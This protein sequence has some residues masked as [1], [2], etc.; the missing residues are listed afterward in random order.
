MEKT[1]HT[2]SIDEIGAFVINSNRIEGILS[3]PEDKI[4]HQSY[5]AACHWTVKASKNCNLLSCQ[6]VHSTI[7]QHQLTEEEIGVWR[8]VYVYVGYQAMPAPQHVATL[9]CQWE[10]WVKKAFQHPSVQVSALRHLFFEGLCIHPFADG[11]GRTFRLLFNYWLLRSGHKWFT[12][13]EREWFSDWLPG[14]RKFEK[15][16]FV[17]KNIH[18]Y[19]KN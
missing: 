7:M 1:H 13:P 15:D 5:V 16:V 18:L 19:P 6:D 10:R 2:P 17:P 14:L 4:H 8:K 12:F 11:N 9:M 3:G